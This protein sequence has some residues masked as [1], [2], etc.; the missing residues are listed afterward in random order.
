MHF[1]FAM[2]MPF[3]KPAKIPVIQPAASA[4]KKLIPDDRDFEII[5]PCFPKK[6]NVCTLFSPT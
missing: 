5:I 3:K 2:I 1:V 4:G 6:L